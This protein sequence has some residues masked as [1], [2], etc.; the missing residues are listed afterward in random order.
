M[1]L[2]TKSLTDHATCVF[3]VEN[4]QLLDIVNKQRLQKECADT[5]N[6]I[7][8][9]K[10]FQDMN[11]VVVNMLLHLTRYISCSSITAKYISIIY[12]SGSR[13]SGGL[14]V[15]MNDIS[16]NMVPYPNM[17]YICSS[18]SPITVSYDR[19]RKQMNG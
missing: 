4:R 15:D 3:P 2:A 7:I 13:F 9:C 12:I 6:Y 17:H 19:Y 10:P 5:L 8:K 1:T 14:N 16:T 18:V 11:T